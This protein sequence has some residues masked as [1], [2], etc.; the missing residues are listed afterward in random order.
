MNGEEVGRQEARCLKCKA[1]FVFF[2]LQ[3]AL[4]CLLIA[5]LLASC[6]CQIAACTAPGSQADVSS[7]QTS[8]LLRSELV[9]FVTELLSHNE[10]VKLHSRWR[11][12][13]SRRPFFLNFCRLFPVSSSNHLDYIL[14]LNFALP[15]F[16]YTGILKL[17]TTSFSG[18]HSNSHLGLQLNFVWV[19][20]DI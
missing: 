16:L 1:P 10:P 18:C 12:F 17:L 3:E 5:C 4:Q 8:L 2:N 15:N 20:D 11:A 7:Y 13:C 9:L 14:V 6:S 19:R